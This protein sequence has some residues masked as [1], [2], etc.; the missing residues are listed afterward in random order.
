MFE[1]PLSDRNFC[2]K[3]KKFAV[4]DEEIVLSPTPCFAGYSQLRN[5][6]KRDGRIEKK[7]ALEIDTIE[8]VSVDEVHNS[9]CE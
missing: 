3:S 2:R 6:L 8:I 5:E 4:S 1:A 7:N 9:L